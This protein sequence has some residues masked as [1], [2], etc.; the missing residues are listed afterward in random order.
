MHG[1]HPQYLGH[2]HPTEAHYIPV[3]IDGEEY[4][5]VKVRES[6]FDSVPYPDE[7]LHHLSLHMGRPVAMISD[8]TYRVYGPSPVAAY[9]SRRPT[10]GLR[11]R[12]ARLY[13]D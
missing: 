7:M 4:A 12:K 10:L 6:A 9:L 8:R 5:L 13:V 11:W 3:H 1:L 2:G